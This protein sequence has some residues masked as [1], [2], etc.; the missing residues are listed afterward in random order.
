MLPVIAAASLY[1]VSPYRSYTGWSRDNSRRAPYNLYVNG[2]TVI[3]RAPKAT[4]ARDMGF[5]FAKAVPVGGYKAT[6]ATMAWGYGSAMFDY[7]KTAGAYEV[8]LNGQRARAEESSRGQMAATVV[9]QYVKQT[10]SQFWV[11]GGG[12][13]PHAQTIGSGDAV[14]MRDGVAYKVRWHRANARSGTTF[15]LPDG[16]LLPFKP[17]QLW[18]V[19]LDKKRKATITPMTKRP[20]PPSPSPIPVSSPTPAAPATPPSAEPAPVTASASQGV[21]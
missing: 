6:K 20:I 17:G 18:I 7:D 9:I 16:S 3:A 19:L 1:D 4:E 10:K 11:K 8:S 12:N 5:V 15:T 21:Q 2:S 14:V 13:T